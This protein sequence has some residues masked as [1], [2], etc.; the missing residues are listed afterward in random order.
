MP[1]FEFRCAKCGKLF[2][3]LFRDSD[4][5]VEIKCP[6]CGSDLVERVISKTNYAMGSG[7]SKQTTL[8]KRQCGTNSCAT[9]EIPGVGD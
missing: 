4:E 2:E 7:K 9:L 6:D 8:T 1:I 3:K 5:K